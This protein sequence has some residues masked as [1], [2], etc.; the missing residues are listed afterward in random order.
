MR[1]PLK[2]SLPERFKN[3]PKE[4]SKGQPKKSLKVLLP[5]STPTDPRTPK[6]LL[7]G[8]FICFLIEVLLLAQDLSKKPVAGGRAN[9]LIVL[10]CSG[11]SEF[12]VLILGA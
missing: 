10:A 2:G 3:G 11:R 5:Y 7:R 12:P 8:M 1:L 9:G 6:S 4:R